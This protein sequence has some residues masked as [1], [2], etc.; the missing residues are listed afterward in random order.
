MSAPHDCDM[1]L[2]N[3]KEDSMDGLSLERGKERVGD[4]NLLEDTAKPPQSVTKN[5]PKTIVSVWHPTGSVSL[6][7]GVF[8]GPPGGE[9]NVSLA[10][11]RWCAM[12]DQEP[13]PSGP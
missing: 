12:R 4:W 2:L 6:L 1:C 8:P 5:S 9:V 3:V 11:L 10:L 13:A 7:S